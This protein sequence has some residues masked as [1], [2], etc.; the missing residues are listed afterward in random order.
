MRQGLL[1]PLEWGALLAERDIDAAKNAL[2]YRCSV[3]G[4]SMWTIMIRYTP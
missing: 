4:F 1:S 2:K 3:L